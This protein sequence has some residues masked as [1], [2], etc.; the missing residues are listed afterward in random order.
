M[1][2]IVLLALL[3]IL[4][5]APMADT[6]P[7]IAVIDQG[8]QSTYSN[9]DRMEKVSRNDL[10]IWGFYPG[11]TSG[12]SGSSITNHLTAI[13]AKN[14][15]VK[16]AQYTIVQ[17][18]N[19]NDSFFDDLEAYADTNDWW[20]Y[21]F[22]DS[23]KETT[24]SANSYAVNITTWAPVDGSGYRYP[25]YY[26]NHI[27]SQFPWSL[28][29]FVFIDNVFNTS[30]LISEPGDWNRDDVNN[31]S[32]A[33]TDATL[34]SRYRSGQVAYVTAFASLQPDI[35]TIANAVASNPLDQEYS[36]VYDGGLYENL[37]DYS[38]ATVK[39]RVEA[40]IPN[41]IDEGALIM[42]V[43]DAVSQQQGRFWLATTMILTNGY[44]SYTNDAVANW[45]IVRFDEYDLDCG[46]AIDSKQSAAWSNGV[47]KREFDNCLVL[48]NPS[49]SQQ[50]VTLPAG[51]WYTIRGCLDP[52][53]N[54]GALKTSLTLAN[55][56]GRILVKTLAA[57][58]NL[59][60]ASRAT[61]TSMT[62]PIGYS[63]APKKRARR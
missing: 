31:S 17:Q 25:Q 26:A 23:T 24:G 22:D 48:V 4:C 45:Y 49:G 50:T 56:D 63:L 21:N 61:C 20:V 42:N 12:L 44:F 27:Q 60:G 11:Q 32:D 51:N 8:Y 59:R 13:D 9:A 28:F 14:P 10:I 38:F 47:Y 19:W 3:L 46:D 5:K 58:I 7:K 52:T 57:P 33:N 43:T 6:Y 39:A 34:T 15:A 55:A 29:D 35:E 53:N 36:G 62:V 2:R 30:Q 40:T 54:D 37:Q 18:I 1:T 16:H 41:L